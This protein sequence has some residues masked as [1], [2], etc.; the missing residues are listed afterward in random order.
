LQ[1]IVSWPL[2]SC[3]S[4]FLLVESPIHYY[5][6]QETLECYPTRAHKPYELPKPVRLMW[7]AF[8]GINGSSG[9]VPKPQIY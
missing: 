6:T 1:A 3:F 7:A 5:G 4:T 2:L 8:G 9:A